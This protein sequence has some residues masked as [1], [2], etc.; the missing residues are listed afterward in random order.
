MSFCK[1]FK[2]WAVLEQYI[3]PPPP[4]ESSGAVHF[5]NLVVVLCHVS[6]DKP[7]FTVGQQTVV[8]I[9]YELTVLISRVPPLEAALSGMLN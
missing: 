7:C 2:T 3:L 6:F 5:R 9:T 1:I 4:L 8:G